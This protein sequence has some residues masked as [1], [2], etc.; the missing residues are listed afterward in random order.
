MP[1]EIQPAPQNTQAPPNQAEIL[2]TQARIPLVPQG[3]VSQQENLDD[4]RNAYQGPEISDDMPKGP[5]ILNDVPKVNFVVPQLEEAHQKFKAIEDRLSMMEGSSDPIDLANMCLVP[6]LVLPPKFKV[7]D[8]EK[9]KALNCPKNHMIMYS[10]KMAFFANN[11]K[12]MMHC[13]QDSLTGASL[14]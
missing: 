13:F 11:D 4:P 12:L 7:P 5:E 3:F 9:Y 1:T 10:R 8:Y 14:N 6:D 2:N